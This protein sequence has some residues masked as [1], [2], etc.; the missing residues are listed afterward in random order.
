[1]KYVSLIHALNIP[2][3]LETNGDWH[4]SA[5]KWKNINMLESTNIIWGNYGIEK[6][7]KL[8]EHSGSYNVA[9]HIRALLDMLY[10]NLFQEAQGM[11]KEFICNS[12]YDN[13]IFI[14]VLKLVNTANWD[15]INEFMNKEYG[16]KWRN[17]KKE[18]L[19]YARV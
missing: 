19:K 7:K 16:N 18:V 5:I 1:M 8:P 14:N 10:L 2:C 11:N 6:N 13:E 15:K 12:K 9:N 17:F 4:K 3:S